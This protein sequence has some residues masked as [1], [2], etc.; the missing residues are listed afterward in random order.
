MSV[1]TAFLHKEV[2]GYGH[3]AFLKN[4]SLKIPYHFTYTSTRTCILTWV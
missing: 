2:N 3:R 4:D 1:N